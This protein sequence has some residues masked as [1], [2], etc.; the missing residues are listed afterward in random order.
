MPGQKV[1]VV[2][3]LSARGLAYKSNRVEK[4][5]APSL[6]GDKPLANPVSSVPSLGYFEVDSR[7]ITSSVHFSVCI[8]KLKP[9]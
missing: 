9:L 2:H 1:V 7:H 8:S 5:H 3:V 4:F 6:N